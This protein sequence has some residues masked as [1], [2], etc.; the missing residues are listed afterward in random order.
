MRA[1]VLGS[2]IEHSL[3]PV[4]H[5]AAYTGLGLAGE[6][7]YG[8]FECDEAG[9]PGFVA[10]CDATWAGLSLTMPLKKV[11]LELADAADGL[12]VE[13]GGAN[14]LVF[15]EGRVHAYNTD[16]AGIMAALRE[17]GIAEVR[18]ATVLGGGATAASAVAALRGLGARAPGA[19]TVLARDPA[20]AAG[21]EEAAER[22]GLRIDARP[23]S[24]IEKHVD[25]DLVVS[26]LPAGAAD[27][28][29]PVV[30]AGR[31][32]LFDVV[33]TPWPTELARAVAEGAPTD[34]GGP[35]AG[36]TVVGGFPMLLHQAAVQVEL[37]TG[38]EQAPVEAMR[39]AGEAEL[40]RRAAS[41]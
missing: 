24:E 6:W 32:P 26:T 30:A 12:A 23:L 7:S 18:S 37:M 15:R 10:G 8:R 28:L 22:M 1:A 40:R 9:L 5:S 20:R 38:V 17:A 21:V 33:Y 3:S 19:I 16:V 13:V 39:A 41:R 11:A 31:A 29:A 35:A 25:A 2:P 27:G 34:T 14:T 4:L 36:R